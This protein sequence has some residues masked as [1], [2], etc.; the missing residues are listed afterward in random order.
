MSAQDEQTWS[1]IAHLSVLAGLVG[2]VP[3]GA[4]V[5]WLIYKDRSPR[6]RFHAAQAFWYQLAWIVIFTVYVLITIV[7]SILTLGIATVVLVPL[8]FLLALAPL[9]HG[10]YAAYKVSQGVDYRYPYIADRI[11][12]GARRVL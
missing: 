6:V 4:L 1:V 7:L 10:C 5:V 11:D 2:L 8:A 3:F 9:A 12:G